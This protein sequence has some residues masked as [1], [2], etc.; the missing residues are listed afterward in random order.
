MEHLTRA[1]T[2]LLLE[3]LNSVWERMRLYLDLHDDPEYQT[4]R[5]LQEKLI[6]H[7]EKLPY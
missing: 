5:R 1:E 6:A 4:L 7:L 2:K 3:G